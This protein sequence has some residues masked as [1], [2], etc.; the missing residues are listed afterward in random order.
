[1]QV[2]V[3]TAGQGGT[4]VGAEVE[5]G[6]LKWCC[7]R[8]CIGLLFS[9]AW[10]QG[11]GAVGASHPAR[12]ARSAGLGGMLHA[13]RP[14]SCSPLRGHNPLPPP[15]MLHPEQA[16]FLQHPEQAREAI[17][18]AVKLQKAAP[19][20][21]PTQ[22]GGMSRG[23]AGS[24]SARLDRLNALLERGAL[25]PEEVARVRTGVLAAHDDP[26]ERLCESAGLVERQLITGAEFAELKASLLEQMALPRVAH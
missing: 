9:F 24:L 12:A 3:Q 26:T 16:M 7:N 10:L 1:M 18:L 19:S 4:A 2:N 15:C 25:T 23:G 20:T 22:L 21:A 5:V 11:V 13:A 14:C 8:R 6:V 17:R